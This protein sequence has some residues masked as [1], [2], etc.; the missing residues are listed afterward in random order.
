MK[1]RTKTALFFGIFFLIITIVTVV[2]VEYVV[3]DTFKKQTINDFRI[4]AEQTESAYVV[5]MEN[6][7]TRG[8]D[9]TSDNTLRNMAKATADSGKRA[10][11]SARYAKEFADYVREK[12][13]P[14][15]K[16][17]FLVDLLDGNGTVIAS[18]RSKRIGVDEKKEEV[19][20]NAHYF[21]KTIVSKFGEA[22][23]KSVVFEEDEAPEPMFHVSVRIFTVDKDGKFQPT[24]TVLL[25]HFINTEKLAGVLNGEINP[26]AGRQTGRALL[27]SYK[28]SEI[29]LVNNARLMVTPSRYVQNIAE[30]KKVDTLPV[31]ECLENG[32]EI[33]EEYDN[34]Q[35]AR[36]LGVSMCFKGDG[37]VLIVEIQ[38]D[39]VYKP[40]YALI[41]LTV[42]GGVTVLVLGIL[43]AVLFVRRPL[44]YISDIVA[45]AKRVADG[46][47]NAR[48]NVQTKDEIGFLASM[49]NTM[50]GSVHSVQ[51]DLEASK[52]EVE[53]KTLM[54]E[55]DIAE[56]EKQEKFLEASKKATINLLE[57]S[58]RIGEKLKVE[59]N[60]L[61]TIIASI[62][63]GLL[64][65]DDSYSI[66][67]VNTA[68]ASMFGMTREELFKKDLRTVATLW[69]KRNEI[70]PVAQ[71]P[72]EEVFLTK[73]IIEV[74]T[75]DELSISTEKHPEKLP[76]AFSVAP[77]GSGIHGVVI[78]FRDVT[79]DQELNEAK[80]GF[81]SVASHQLR[82]PLTSIRWYSEMLLSGDVG[83]LN[84][85]QKDFMTEVHS[86]AERLYQTVDL[87]LGI[88]R[89]ESGKI[90]TEKQ[91]IDLSKFTV[92]IT[93]ELASQIDEKGCALSIS[94]PAG[95]PVVVSLDQL[96]LRQVILNLFSNAIRYTN[97]KDG[98]IE[99]AWRKNEAGSE[100]IY[101]VRDNGIGI[102][103]AV[104]ERVFSKFFRAE[105]ARATVPDGSGLGLALVKELVESWGGRVW[106]ESEEGKGSA[107]FFTVPFVVQ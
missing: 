76:I 35:G 50:I 52:R 14:F 101:S 43:V 12:K 60:K 53:G 65:I 41:R 23:V 4:I 61:Q 57:E 69:K 100:V 67:L 63:D 83:S 7:K 97:A 54:L 64:L 25:M 17:V 27:S 96:T 62:G 36:V 66:V 81:I 51:K 9:W 98:I 84:E 11:R 89:V 49:F 104:R 90:K 10:R 1:L 24:D 56:H 95:G 55:K 107:F 59:S 72:I 105:N 39:E 92:E 32:N 102:P 79:T 37:L 16:T 80:S 5:F 99:V 71:W 87:L 75:D 40:L 106:F 103:V 94:S 21:S 45:T 8:L 26:Q 70:V 46:D 15:D 2:Y 58:W 44:A 93:K 34:Y 74:T 31:S 91:P 85:A 47:L 78:V 20:H 86:G 38:K 82:T 42:A 29:Y 6:M 18:T 30:Y 88:S 28:T 73:K 33:S 77:L 13:M 22:F 3:G 68:A 48:V 19:L